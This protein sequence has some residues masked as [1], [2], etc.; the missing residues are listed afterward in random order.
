MRIK[1]EIGKKGLEVFADKAFLDRGQGGEVDL[2][3]E[4]RWEIML[5]EPGRVGRIPI[6]LL[7]NGVV[8][9]PY[10]W[11]HMWIIDQEQS[12]GK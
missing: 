9:R 3:G 2:R 8:G 11:L 7:K 4:F 10:F 6:V 5:Q 1:N 12:S